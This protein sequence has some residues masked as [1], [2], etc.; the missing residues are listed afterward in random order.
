MAGK[1][2]DI[3]V[4]VVGEHAG[5]GSAAGAV[6]HGRICGGCTARRRPE[7][8]AVA[9]WRKVG[10]RR[11]RRLERDAHTIG[12]WAWAFRRAAPR[13]WFSN[14]VVVPPRAGRG[15]AGRVEGV[16]AGVASWHRPVQLE[17]EGGAPVCNE[18]A[19]AEPEQLFELPDRGFVLKQRLVKADPVRREAFVSWPEAARR[20]E[21]KIF[22]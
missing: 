22:R 12:Q 8:A 5:D 18:R 19:G 11:W 3:G 20:T 13:R 16:G 14:R 17:L 1:D 15:A 2:Q 10:L 9:Y 4:G 6:V 21:A 7:S